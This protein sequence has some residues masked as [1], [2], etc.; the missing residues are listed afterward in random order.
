MPNPESIRNHPTIQRFGSLLDNPNL[1]HLNRHSVAGALATGLF[2]AFV[3]V[4]FQM[5][6]AAAVAIALRVNLPLSVV[7]VWLSNPA[8]IP[9]IF[10]F[11]Y[12]VGA[13]T[14]D[15]PPDADFACELSFHWLMHSLGNIWQP[16]LLGCLIM[17]V[18]SSIFGYF[19][20]QLSWRWCVYRQLRIRKEKR[21]I[22]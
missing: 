11:C 1:W 15:A 16:F 17:S 20:V 3:P 14:I 13:W 8:T 22:Q 5:A 10:Y 18:T 19:F 7:T 2:M 9:P 21:I 6:L 12:L 4:P